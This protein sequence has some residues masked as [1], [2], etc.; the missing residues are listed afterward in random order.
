MPNETL[1]DLVE[2]YNGERYAGLRKPSYKRFTDE[3]VSP[4]DP[5]AAPMR[6]QGG[7]SAILGYRDHYIVGDGKARII[8]S[9]LVSPASI[10]GITPLLDMVDWTCYRGQLGPK[11][12]VG[13]AKYGTVPNIVGLEERGI[14]ANLPTP[15]LSKLF[16]YYLADLSQYNAGNNHYI[17]P[18]EQI[19]PL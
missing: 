7:G 2:K 1:Q 12:A 18:Q 10:M 13:D 11:I 16:E 8:L 3:K 15:D 9:V 6:A 19:L 17:C 4:T 14:K 5:D